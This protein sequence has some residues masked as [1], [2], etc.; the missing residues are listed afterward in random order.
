M[1]RTKYREKRRDSVN[2]EKEAEFEQIITNEFYS[3]WHIR[4]EFKNYRFPE[5]IDEF[6]DEFNCQS[7]HFIKFYL[8]INNGNRN[9]YF[10]RFLSSSLYIPDRYETEFYPVSSIYRRGLRHTLKQSSHFIKSLTRLT[11]S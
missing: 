7:K 11:L 2:V 6:R 1:I 5:Y 4:D 3:F 9:L 10:G 8:M